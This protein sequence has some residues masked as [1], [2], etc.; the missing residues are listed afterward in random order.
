MRTQ[1]A[2]LKRD[3]IRGRVS[4]R[5]ILLEPAECIRSARVFDMLLAIPRCGRVKATKVLAQC[6]IPTN[7]TVGELSPGQREKLLNLL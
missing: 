7:A 1:R 4:L 2:Q 3:L 5:S 6:S